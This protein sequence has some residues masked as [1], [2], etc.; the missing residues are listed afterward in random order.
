MLLMKY[1]WYRELIQT[2][3][4]EPKPTIVKSLVAQSMSL[5]GAAVK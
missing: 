3:K 5:A 2:K 1:Q 4:S